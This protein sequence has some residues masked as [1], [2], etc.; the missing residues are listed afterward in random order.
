MSPDITPETVRELLSGTTAG[1]WSASRVGGADFR[2]GTPA[3]TAPVARLR[4]KRGTAADARLMAAAPALAHAY[5]EQAE[6]LARLTRRASE[7]CWAVEQGVTDEIRTAAASLMLLLGFAPERV[8][9]LREPP[10]DA[11]RLRAALAELVE[12]HRLK[13]DDPEQYV[14]CGERKGAAWTMAAAVL[15]GTSGG[16]P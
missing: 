7:L 1:L 5:L 11:A 16:G 2:I 4:L 8:A 13:R 14:R 15:A 3:A 9:A 10:D 6:V 12:L